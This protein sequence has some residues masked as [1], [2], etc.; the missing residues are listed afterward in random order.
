[1]DAQQLKGARPDS[2]VHDFGAN[3][4]VWRFEYI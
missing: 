2:A 1:M 3:L 4:E